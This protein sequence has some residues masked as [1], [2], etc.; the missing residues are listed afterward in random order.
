MQRFCRIIPQQ[1]LELSKR[2]PGRGE[3]LRRIGGLA[4]DRTFNEGEH[5]PAAAR[6]VPEERLAIPCT[7]HPQRTAFT[8]AAGLAQG[9]NQ[10][11]GDIHNVFH[12]L[13]R[14]FKRNRAHPLQ[15]KAA[16]ALLRGIYGKGV[17]DMPFPVALCFHDRRAKVKS[18]KA[19]VEILFGCWHGVIPS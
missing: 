10:V 3:Q 11:V 2:L 19:F 18:G 4:A 1:L 7:D 5:A 12:Q 17:V 14:F 13:C 9:A 6:A 16:A 8:V 15:D